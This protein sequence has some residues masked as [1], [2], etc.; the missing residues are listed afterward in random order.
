MYLLAQSDAA[1][2]PLPDRSVDLVFGSPPYIDARL[3]LEDGLDLGISRCC[4]D[5]VDW[6]LCVTTEA[7]RVSRGLVL[8]VCAGVTRDWNYRPGP[9]G[10]VWEWYKRGNKQWRPAY[11]HRSGIPGSGNRKWL[12]SD[13]EYV[14]AFKGEGIDF[15]TDNTAMG[16][17]PKWAPGGD[18]S[19]RLKSGSRRNQ[20]G[21]VNGSTAR[22][23]DGSMAKM[24]RPSHF[25]PSEHTKRIRIADGSKQLQYYIPPVLANPGNLVQ[26]KNGGGN[27]GSK[28]AY[29]NE[30][31]FPE[32][33]AEFFVRSFC[34]PGGICLD[35]FSGSGTTCAVAERFDR[36][37]IGMDLRLSQCKLGAA[38]IADGVRP[39]SKLDPTVRAPAPGQMGL[40]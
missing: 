10:L 8:W 32:D 16:H 21:M 9:E 18:M 39:R 33:L 1:R 27:I 25:Y 40:F 31:P 22:K 15:W 12:R 14:L 30:A 11:W 28:M 6:M 38:R 7:V 36:N 13:I 35:P 26:T 4:E 20:W 24:D 2:I 5:W 37:G 17:T 34:P 19:Y 23:R 29:E 3:Y